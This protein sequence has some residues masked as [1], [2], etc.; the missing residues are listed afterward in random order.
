MRIFAMAVLCLLVL[1]VAGI[2]GY[3]IFSDLPAP[4]RP[5]ELPVKSQ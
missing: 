5:V 4:I 1:G 2:I 3:A